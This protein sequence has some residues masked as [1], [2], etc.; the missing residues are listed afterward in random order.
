MD[1]I[2]P[3]AGDRFLHFVLFFV[4]SL[5]FYWVVETTRRR[6]LQFTLT[7]CT[8]ILGVGS[9][10]LQDVLPNGRAFDVYDIL[11]NILGSVS[12]TLCCAWYHRRMLDRRRRVGFAGDSGGAAGYTAA[13]GEDIELGETTRSDVVEERQSLYPVPG[14][15][16][17]SVTRN[18]L[19]REVDNWDENAF[20]DDSWED[21]D[22]DNA[23]GSKRPQELN[24]EASHITAPPKKKERND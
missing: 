24:N 3:T 2:I 23:D 6:A 1:A 19:Q 9:E 17:G 18:E 16:S 15:E 22:S 20:G 11:A 13:G 10:I 8:F 7:F 4:L 21:Y 14:Q 12:A 5:V